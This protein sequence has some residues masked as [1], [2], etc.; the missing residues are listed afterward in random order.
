[1]IKSILPKAKKSFADQT[2]SSTVSEEKDKAQENPSEDRI[3]LN[4]DSSFDAFRVEL[5]MKVMDDDEEGIKNIKECI[6]SS[7]LKQ[8][9]R[10]IE[11]WTALEEYY[12]I[13]FGKGGDFI[14]FEALAKKHPENVNVQKFLALAYKKYNDH[15]KAAILFKFAAEKSK[16]KDE[17][18]SLYG[19]AAISFANDHRNQ[20]MN[21]MISKMKAL[22]TEVEN[23]ENELIE[24]LR[25]IAEITKDNDL[26][27]GVTEQLLKINPGDST[28]RF[29]LAYRYSNNNQDEL[30]FF[31]YLIIPHRERNQ[32][33]WNNLGV[34]YDLFNMNNNS[35]KAY[36]Q[37]EQ[38]GNTLAM[39]NLA[40]KL[41]TA[42]FLEE[43]EEICNRAFKVK[44]YHKN[45]LDDVSKIKA[46]PDEEEKQEKTILEKVKPLNEFYRE[47]GCASLLGNPGN[48]EGQWRGH[49]CDLEVKISDDSF[50]AI[51]KY[52]LA[53]L[54]LN[55]L[56]S[57]VTD[58]IS[59]KK[60]YNVKYEGRVF[61]RTIKGLFTESVDEEPHLVPQTA[62]LGSRETDKKVE[63]LM[64]LSDSLE[65]IRVYEKGKSK[66]FKF[67]S[68]KRIN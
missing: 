41:I 34:A 14:R 3:E 63:V 1:M 54:G 29:N 7:K 60:R 11:E 35:I 16:N 45:V 51:G 2:E 47:Y 57:V 6:L 62:L 8:E 28:S 33:S 21:L 4:A 13:S 53:G 38:M 67:Y 5:Y 23:S 42:G 31:H 26:Y 55:F 20:E 58:A 19:K 12:R 15:F 68:L 43:A 48:I 44:D 30:S 40:K 39:S 50:T 27:F 32:Y 22:T 24:T 49:L 61:G 52:E 66:D 46:I 9:Q 17:E 56:R 37:A 65:E 10:K 18:L 25:E 64:I 59:N 36:K